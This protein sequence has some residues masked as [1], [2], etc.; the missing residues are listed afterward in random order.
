MIQAD[1][2][3][4]YVVR[5]NTYNAD[6]FNSVA[7]HLNGFSI[8]RY[9]EITA[10]SIFCNEIIASFSIHTHCHWSNGQCSGLTSTYMYITYLITERN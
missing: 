5:L 4:Y 6:Y 10:I 9:M 1:G 2:I 8:H 7:N 3:K